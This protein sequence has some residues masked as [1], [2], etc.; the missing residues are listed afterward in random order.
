MANESGSARLKALEKTHVLDEATRQRR[1]KKAIEALEKDNYQDD[2][3]T[4]SLYVSDSRIQ[5][6]KKFQ[7]KFAVADES[8][9]GTSDSAAKEE[10]ASANP[11]EGDASAAKKRRFKPEAKWRVKKSFATLVDEEVFTSFLLI[12]KSGT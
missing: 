11:N 12:I 6:N 1:Q 2:M 5:M 3:P 7:Q 9:P 10:S 4:S 8:T